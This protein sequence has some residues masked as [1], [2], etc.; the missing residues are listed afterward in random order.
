MCI[1]TLRG[2]VLLCGT[3][4]SICTS[5]VA[6]CDMSTCQGWYCSLYWLLL[7][8]AVSV[9]VVQSDQREVWSGIIAVLANDVFDHK[10]SYAMPAATQWVQQ[11]HASSIVY[12]RCT[13]PTKL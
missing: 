1:P 11:V 6:W 13:V 8:S 4:R 12:V 5:H 9:S 10:L 7:V 3:L 2:G